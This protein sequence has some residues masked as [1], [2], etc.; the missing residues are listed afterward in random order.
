MQNKTETA[1]PTH[2]NSAAPWQHCC[3]S[4]H[5]TARHSRAQQGACRGMNSCT[6]A[7]CTQHRHCLCTT[8]HHALGRLHRSL[9][10]ECNASVGCRCN[11]D[12][13][14]LSPGHRPQTPPAHGPASQP[15]D[16]HTHRNPTWPHGPQTHTHHTLS[17][18]GSRPTA[19]RSTSGCDSILRLESTPY[20][21]LSQHC[22]QLTQHPNTPAPSYCSLTVHTGVPLA[23]ALTRYAAQHTC[24]CCGRRLLR[25]IERAAA[26]LLLFRR[27]P[28]APLLLL[29][30]GAAAD[31]CP[32]AVQALTDCSPAA[33]CPP[34]ASCCSGAD[35]C[36][37]AGCCPAARRCQLL[38]RCLRLSLH[39][40]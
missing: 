21:S 4:W 23:A 18:P 34:A 39:P 6:C 26:P 2:L 1:T 16:P 9:C 7:A 22:T 27:W 5:S 33:D 28:T 10:D 32:A 38:F 25:L 24:C 37:G 31:C 8:R 12:P 40:P 20:H 30:E 19:P 15:T 14:H 17:R 3:C 13:T 36:S 35:C 11:T 29:I